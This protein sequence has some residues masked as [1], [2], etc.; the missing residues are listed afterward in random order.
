MKQKII[1]V[2]VCLKFALGVGFTSTA[3]AEWHRVDSNVAQVYSEIGEKNS[4]EV[5]EQL[6][7]YD[8]VLRTMMGSKEDLNAPPIKVFVVSNYND[9]KYVAPK[10][11]RSA[12]GFYRA[13]PESIVTVL[14]GYDDPNV[15]ILDAKTVLQHEYAHHF[16]YRNF[17]GV[18]PQWFVEGFAEYFSTIDFN[19]EKA[20]IGDLSIARYATLLKR[21]M[22]DVE[23]FFVD[24]LRGREVSGLYATAWLAT[25]YFYS[26]TER[27]AQLFQYI[28]DQRAGSDPRLAFENA[29]GMTIKDFEKRLRTYLKKEIGAYVVSVPRQNSVITKPV[30]VSNSN[31]RDLMLYER[32]AGS[33]L[34]PEDE[35]VDGEEILRLAKNRANS[36]GASLTAQKAWVL[37]NIKFGDKLLALDLAESLAMQTPSDTDLMYLH[38]YAALE[39]SGQEGADR[40]SFTDNARANLQQVMSANPSDYRAYFKLGQSYFLSEG[41]TSS[42]ALEAMINAYRLAPEVLPLTVNLAIL[43]WS[44]GRDHEARLLLTPLANHPHETK[45]A[46]VAGELLDLMGDNTDATISH[47][48][49]Q[50]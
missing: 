14:I 12:I 20:V 16:M 18:Y 3:T 22:L 47:K 33:S 45:I 1:S 46:T 7:R 28:R 30:S 13:T 23:L 44:Q 41:A 38:G 48:Y 17:S 25:H 43:L 35:D 37:A 2:V 15:R 32:V 49:W 5:A 4:I 21:S 26:S 42:E 31:A 34:D 40:I 36:S 19:D 50:Q 29:I 10:V 6:S 39:A 24:E 27:Q 11:P 8:T 9:L